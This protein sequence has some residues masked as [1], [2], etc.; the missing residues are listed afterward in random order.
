MQP[1][2]DDRRNCDPTRVVSCERVSIE[3]DD[4]TAPQVLDAIRRYVLAEAQLTGT[5]AINP[6]VK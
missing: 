5:Y 4:F 1:C 6:G 2:A 3:G